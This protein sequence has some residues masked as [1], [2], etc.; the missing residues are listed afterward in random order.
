VGYGLGLIFGG[1]RL[2]H[3]RLLKLLTEAGIYNRLG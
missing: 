3:V 1:G 2:I